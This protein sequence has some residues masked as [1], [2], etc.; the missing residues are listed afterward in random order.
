MEILSVD[1]SLRHWWVFLLRGILFILVGI[2]M[3]CSPGTGFVALG[4]FFGLII[5]LTGL[6]ELLHATRHRNAGNRSWHLGLGIVEIILGIVLMSHVAA[7]VTIVRLIVGLYFVLRGF[8]LISFS[9]V[10]GKSLW[11]TIGGIITAIFGLL[12]I[13]NAVFGAMTI[14]IF[15]AIAFIITGIFNTWLGFSMK[16]GTA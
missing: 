16:K 12:I 8:S 9:R 1:R 2:Y 5:F 6:A 3:I 7:G 15:I 13:F 10:V 4:F 14:I 11:L